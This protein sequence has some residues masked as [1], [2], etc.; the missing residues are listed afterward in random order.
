MLKV[1]V[2]GIG[3]IGSGIVRRLAGNGNVQVVMYD[4]NR[5]N[6]KAIRSRRVVRADSAAEVADASD[7]I[8]LAVKPRQMDQLVAEIGPRASGKALVS[9]AAG[10][11]S[12]EIAKRAPNSRVYRMMTNIGCEYGIGPVL[13][14]CEPVEEGVMSMAKRLGRVFLVDEDS[15]DGL[16]PVVGSGPAIISYLLDSLSRFSVI[17]GV[18]KDLADEI[19]NITA[20]STATYLVKKGDGHEGVVAKV[21]TPA[22]VTIKA[23]HRLDKEGVVGKIVEALLGI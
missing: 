12:S 11:R 2:I 17:K 10:Y 7:I 5:S 15:I 21:A 1:G 19:V 23:I 4:R 3:N 6:M 18:E 13:L 8:V 22:G 20:L 16:T 14:C 9:V